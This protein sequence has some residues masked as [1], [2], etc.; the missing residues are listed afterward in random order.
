[1]P[2]TPTPQPWR[3]QHQQLQQHNNK[4]K[5]TQSAIGIT[6][7]AITYWRL[8]YWRLRIGDYD[9][10][11]C[12]LGNGAGVPKAHTRRNQGATK[13][14]PRRNTVP[15]AKQRIGIMD[16]GD[17]V[18][19]GHATIRCRIWWTP[20]AGRPQSAVVKVDCDGILFAVD[21]S[22]GAY[23]RAVAKAI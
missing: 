5:T 12:V 11:D 21:F 7:L 19:S 1:M 10:G 6:L 13:A 3:T 18:F 9:I 2:V 22:V 4:N 20:S 17:Y 14:Q 8:R 16:I 23:P 15:S